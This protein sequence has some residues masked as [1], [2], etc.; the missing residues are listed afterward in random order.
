MS[1]V[2]EG[3]CFPVNRALGVGGSR[4]IR[5]GRRATGVLSRRLAATCSVGRIRNGRPPL[6]LVSKS[7]HDA[8]GRA[9]G[10]PS[11][12]LGWQ[13][14]GTSPRS[15]SSPSPGR[16]ARLRHERCSG[17]G[18]ALLPRA[19]RRLH[20]PGSAEA[21]MPACA[22]P[23]SATVGEQRQRDRVLAE[24]RKRR[25]SANGCGRSTRRPRSAKQQSSAATPRRNHPKRNRHERRERTNALPRSGSSAP[26]Q[27]RDRV[28]RDPSSD[29][30]RYQP[31]DAGDLHRQR[32]PFAR[33]LVSPA[34]GEDRTPRPHARLS[35][36]WAS[37]P[38]RAS[39]SPPV[40]PRAPAL[41]IRHPSADYRTCWTVSAS[42]KG[43]GPLPPAPLPNG[44]GREAGPE[45]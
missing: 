24:P 11:L 7:S 19:S 29:L 38:L 32:T 26:A 37:A 43:E 20:S 3:C 27:P 4:R 23:W 31:A 17:R 13:S 41:G 18:G 44:L 15:E 45:R 30:A 36:T 39:A 2:P 35:L 22:L 5:N 28:R 8:D 42:K 25:G 12:S 14:G 40:E 21:F 9:F 16:S 1:N 33:V 34:C 10:R 6:S